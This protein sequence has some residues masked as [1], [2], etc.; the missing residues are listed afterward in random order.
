MAT[1]NRQKFE[2]GNTVVQGL[3]GRFHKNISALIADVQPTNLLEVGCG[4]GFFLA[5]VKRRLPELPVLGLDVNQEALADGRRL[6]PDLPLRHGDIY[7]LDQPDA[8]WDMVVASEVLE[9][10][11]RPAEA[12]RELR[13]VSR[14][15]VVLSVPWEPWFQL[16][17]LARGKHLHRFGNHPEHVN[18]WNP[19][20]F[21]AWVGTALTV[22]RLKTFS[23]FPWMI[24]L[25]RV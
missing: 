23:A 11:G 12:L 15:Y 1:T 16:G 9:H 25:A 6:F 2:T 14:R 18:H 4:E 19:G 3:I 17:S 24:V 22:E 13:R 8:S 10:L 7:H 21:R 5:A 20:T